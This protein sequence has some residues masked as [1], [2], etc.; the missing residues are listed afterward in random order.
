MSDSSSDSDS[1]SKI[2]ERPTKSMSSAA[3]S[4]KGDKKGKGKAAPG[5]DDSGSDDSMSEDEIASG[6]D[7]RLGTTNALNYAPPRKMRPVKISE[8]SSQFD[9]D[10][11]LANPN[12]ELWAIRIP[13]SI[14]SRHLSGL[15]INLSSSVNKE[16]TGSLSTKTADYV[17]Q[18]ASALGGTAEELASLKVLLP[19]KS[20]EAYVVAPRPIKKSLVLA[21]LASSSLITTSHHSTTI[22]P[23]SVGPSTLY[24]PRV[25][26]PRV[27]PT[28][29]LKFRNKP[30]G[31]GTE[32]ALQPEV[33]PSALVTVGDED[34]VA[35][36]DSTAGEAEADGETETANSKK[37]KAA[38]A[39]AGEPELGE[40]ERFVGL[41]EVRISTDPAPVPA[42]PK[43]ARTGIGVSSEAF[44]AVQRGHQP[45]VYSTW[46]ECLKQA[47]GFSEAIYRKLD[48]RSEANAFVISGAHDAAA[49]GTIASLPVA[50]G[51]K[52]DHSLMEDVSLPASKRS[53]TES[54]MNAKIINQ[55]TANLSS[56]QQ[57]KLPIVQGDDGFRRLPS[58]RVV[59]YTDGSAVKNG[60]RGAFAGSGVFWSSN[61]DLNISRRVPGP[62]QTNNRGELLSILL[63]LE[64]APGPDSPLEIRTDSKYSIDALT[65]WLPNWR[66]REFRT[67]SD[68]QVKNLDLIIHIERL[69]LARRQR[70]RPESELTVGAFAEVVERCSRR[71][72]FV[73]PEVEIDAET[74]E[75]EGVRYERGWGLRQGAV[76]FRWVKGHSG[77]DG[78]EAA[79][80]LANLGACKKVAL[81]VDYGKEEMSRIEERPPDSSSITYTASLPLHKLS[82]RTLSLHTMSAAHLNVRQV[83]GDFT[84]ASRTPSSDNIHRI[85]KDTVGY[86]DSV[87]AGKAAQQVEV[88]K[89][90]ASQGFLPADL[91]K[92]EVNWFYL[93]LGIDDT[94][95]MNETPALIAEHIMALY[96]AKILAYTKHSAAKL[97]IDLERIQPEE[98]GKKEGAIFIHTSEAGVTSTS[99]PGATVEKRIDELYL[100]SSTIDKAYRLETYRSSGSVSA[101]TTQSVR[102][103]FVSRSNLPAYNPPT[104]LSPQEHVEYTKKRTIDQISDPAFLEKASGNTKEI[105]ESVIFEVEKRGFAP[106]IEVYDV[107]GTGE[108]RVVI[109]AKMGGTNNFHSALSDLY[110]FYGLF[111]TRKYVEQFSNGVTVICLYLRNV[112]NSNAP[113]IEHS[114]HQVIKETSLLYSLPDNPFFGGSEQSGHAVQEASYAYAGWIFAQHFCNR[115]GNSYIS[116]KSILDESNPVHAEVLNN[117]KTRFREET[118]T[119]E[120]I[121]DVISTNP[122]LIRLLYINFAMTHYPEVDE[123]S[124][125]MP[126]L[127]YQRL[128]TERPLTDEELYNKI[129]KT[130][131]NSHDIQ[132]IEAFLIFNK[133]VLKT[134]FYQTTK[135]ALSFRLDPA[136]LPKVEYPKTPFGIILVVGSDFRGFHVRFRDVSR[137]GI[138]IVRSRGREQYSI[139]ARSLFDENYGLASTQHLKNKDIPEG[140][141]KGTI[142]PS[143]GANPRV[144]FEHYVDAILDLLLPGKTPGI[145]GPIVDLYGKPEI[146][147][148]GPDE[149]TADMMDWAAG[150]ARSRGA[151]F[152][153]SFTTGKGPEAFGGIPHDEY[154]MTSLSVRQYIL[155]V[156]ATLGWK[157]KDVTKFQTG[158]PD[159]DLGSNEI[160]LSNDKTIAIIDGSGV[161][162]DPSGLNRTELIR[163]AK[164]RIPV[165]NFNSDL[166]GPEGYKILIDDT[167]VVLPSGEKVADGTTFRNGAHL[168][169]KA[170]IFV[171]CGGRPESVNVTNVSKLFDADGKPHFKAVVEGANL[172]FTQQ[173]RLHLEKKGVV[174]YKDSS[175]NKGGV[176]SSSLEVLAGLG[177][178]DEEYLELMLCKNGKSDFYKSYV[179]DIQDMI[180]ENGR[181]EHACIQDE[182]KRRKSTVPRTLLSDELSSTLNALQVE[183]EESHGLYNLE[184]SRRN[185][186]RKA[187]PKTLVDKVGLD[188]L[189]QRLPDEYCRALYSAY[190]ASH[191]LYRSGINAS[192][193][194]FFN[195]FTALNSET[196]A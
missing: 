187:I 101:S 58:G 84:A 191:H 165:E 97:E 25:V 49:D 128:K 80:R 133:H 132:V 115:L 142:L 79:D 129:R 6:P 43:K 41:I 102:C 151:S 160:L 182:Y 3:A 178:S 5:S 139:N 36:M 161:I 147:F 26:P 65:T 183:L 7:R 50:T 34:Q 55:K 174:L 180:C 90:V 176:T 33:S 15:T 14:K 111:S 184:T 104:D 29:K 13:D 172:F 64:S 152:W 166:L 21:P 81:M 24:T 185:V 68:E 71:D 77:E 190:I 105:Y 4:S 125:L 112:P 148:F 67:A 163:L 23:A 28:E 122:Q 154:G 63:A 92:N 193:V 91:V 100:N 149:G 159:G 87:Y 108:M 196:A 73:K 189:L 173:A 131:T 119:R 110:H 2:D 177:L 37:R 192:Q 195:F 137:G 85:R 38:V 62:E 86:K 82:F 66:R 103:Y 32:L 157:E 74:D 40:A 35:V 9:Y 78:N 48:S 18:G 59:V 93:N 94:Y 167:D 136:F 52:R 113:P 169:F 164:A 118:F 27:Q 121:K 181:L 8:A 88:E 162:H 158:G 106:V 89:V 145:K 143:L 188:T 51:T 17:V 138:R 16:P 135:V 12:L 168:R 175:A 69:L 96:G 170:D 98:E 186:F 116:L 30:S 146:L 1:S 109:G 126:T 47:K 20:K 22:Q 70:R 95:F 99:G 114:I 42:L 57:M 153:K 54:G 76:R 10:R 150:H 46:A 156:Y 83:L 127:S 194:D 171:P 130:L 31:Y 39:S 53:N 179:K 134:N 117:I 124:S 120:S 45:G 155:G 107:E 75:E 61:T 141:A 11:L 72:P 56:R 19:S 140:G 123:N 144:C 60:Q 44:Y